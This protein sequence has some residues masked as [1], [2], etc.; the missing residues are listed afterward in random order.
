MVPS[1]ERVEKYINIEQ[2]PKPTKDGIPPAYWPSSGALNVKGLSAR[3]SSEGPKVLQDI[4][5]DVK[6]GERIGIGQYSSLILS[7]IC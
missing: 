7:Y 3:Y 2:E 4:T 1:L 5:F 6:A